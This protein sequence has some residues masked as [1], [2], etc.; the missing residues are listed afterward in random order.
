MTDDK[1]RPQNSEAKIQNPGVWSRGTRIP[2]KSDHLMLLSEDPPAS[3]SSV[4][5]QPVDFAEI[6]GVLEAD[7][8]T[9]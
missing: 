8:L 7:R 3:Q 1:L 6:A 4:G 2:S 5:F 9:G